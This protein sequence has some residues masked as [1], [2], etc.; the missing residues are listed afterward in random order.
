MDAISSD[1]EGPSSFTAPKS[2]R[3]NQ[4]SKLLRNRENKKFRLDTVEK[5][6]LKKRTRKII[7]KLKREAMLWEGYNKSTKNMIEIHQMII[8]KKVRIY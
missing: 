2:H 5:Q 3:S 7:S 6:N 8:D 4:L 1:E